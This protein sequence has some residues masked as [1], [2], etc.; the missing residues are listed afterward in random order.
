MSVVLTPA[1]K[2]IIV[3]DTRLQTALVGG[4]AVLTADQEVGETQS[5][6]LGRLVNIEK[7]L[8][9]MSDLDLEED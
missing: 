2:A 4:S 6:I 7:C 3:V 5:K 9:K 1:P 8:K